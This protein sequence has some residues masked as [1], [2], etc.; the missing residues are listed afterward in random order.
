MK[1]LFIDTETTGLPKSNNLS[2]TD[3]ENWPRLVSVAYILTEDREVVDSNYYIIKPNGFIVPPESTKV[4]GITTADAI[5]RGQVLS[6]TLDILKQKIDECTFIVGHNVEFDINVLNSEYYRYNKTLPVSLKPHFCTMK[7]SKDFCGL[8]NNKYPTLEEL[9]SILKGNSFSNAHNAM[10]DTQAAM[11]CFWLLQ[12]SGVL[13]P[14]NKLDVKIY[15]TNDNILWA[16]K[17]TSLSYC[18]KAFALCTIACNLK[19]NKGFLDE[20]SGLGPYK[21]EKIIENPSK[22]LVIENDELVYRDYSEE[23]WIKDS[24]A[25]FNELLKSDNSTK[26][27]AE[28]ICSFEKEMGGVEVIKKYQLRKPYSY[29]CTYTIENEQDWLSIAI[30][31]SKRSNNNSS[32][33]IAYFK[34]MLKVINNIREQWN[35]REAEKHYEMKRYYAKYGVDIDR[36]QVPNAEQVQQMIHDRDS[37]TS[38]TNKSSSNSGCMV[39]LSLI[40]VIGTSIYYLLF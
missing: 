1:Y 29:L 30:Q 26:I 10:A 15:H 18:S 3:T 40:I 17:H 27:I 34:E 14:S 25:F 37:A 24:F 39:V 19:N 23:E 36:G 31:S 5:S 13:K 12:D 35:Q 38:H 22:K 2:P 11:E 7:L 28:A 4:H 21:K 33:A 9:Y 6:E 8:P 16:C 32:S 20:L